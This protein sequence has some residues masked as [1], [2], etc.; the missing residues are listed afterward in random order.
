MQTIHSITELQAVLGNERAANKRIAFVPTMG[1]LH[2]GHIQL[3]HQA[4]R[5]ADITVASIFV[6]PLQFGENEDLDAYPRTLQ[7]DQEK[8]SA[9]DC[10]YLFAP[11]MEDMYP[12][13]Q[14]IQTL[15]EVPGISQLHCG[16]SRPIHFRGV[17]TV[18]CKL[19]GIVRPDVAIFGEKDFQQLMVI[20]RMTEDLFLPVEIQGAPI[21][22]AESG[23]ALSSRNGYLS[24]QEMEI[25][26]TLNRTIRETVAQVISGN[27][28][29][30]QLEE[31]AQQQLEEAGFK[32]DYFNICRRHDLQPAQPEDKELVL[33]A[34][35]YLG[36]ARLIDNMVIDL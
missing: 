5:N 2:E 15:V 16:I 27:H 36:K 14:V 32:R 9:A 11:K 22:R 10:D 29:Y 6:N 25:A 35:A 26:P 23:L 4:N 31:S 7:S 17:A 21:A 13:G 20:R 19:F 1:N 30:S 33:V 3:I 18:V 24:E 34:A 12:N 8:L 28:D